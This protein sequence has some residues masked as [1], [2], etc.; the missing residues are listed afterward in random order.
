ML[1]F[2]PPSLPCCGALALC[3]AA[4]V[5]P[6]AAGGLGYFSHGYQVPVSQEATFHISG[7]ATTG[8]MQGDVFLGKVDYTD[9]TE[10]TQ[11]YTPVAV[12]HLDIEDGHGRRVRTLGGGNITDGIAGRY[13]AGG[14]ADGA[15]RSAVTPA[16]LDAF[17]PLLLRVQANKN[18]N[19]YL[20][21]QHGYKGVEAVQFSYT[22]SFEKPVRDSDPAPDVQGE[23]L[24]FERGTQGGNSWIT[25]QAVD[26]DGN[27]LGPAL[28]I[29][30]DETYVTTPVVDVKQA[31]QQIGGLAIDVSRLGVSEVQHLRVRNTRATDDGYGPVVTSHGSDHEPDHK[32]MAVITHPDDLTVL[33]ALYD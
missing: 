10:F 29:S 25:L 2:N 24:Y 28:A 17:S 11:F 21:T 5:S 9:G 4:A 12:R 31:G 3:G 6:A 14:Y 15:S 16:D 32:I 19:N 30:P 8:D 22:I 23:I 18:L 26:E 33:A 7:S 1:T 20:E 13:M 27:A